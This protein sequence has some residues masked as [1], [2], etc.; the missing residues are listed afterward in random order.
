MVTK[1][2][3]GDQ[4]DFL[5]LQKIGAESFVDITHSDDYNF[6]VLVGHSDLGERLGQSMIHNT[7]DIFDLKGASNSLKETA[8]NNAYMAAKNG[9]PD[10]NCEFSGGITK[11]TEGF[12]TIKTP[13]TNQCS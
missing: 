11:T 5:W 1:F 13:T 8:R 9:L 7:L 3:T 4:P 6:Y 10:L 12:T 2:D